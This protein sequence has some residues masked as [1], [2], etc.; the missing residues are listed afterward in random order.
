[1]NP[2]EANQ[3]EATYNAR[4]AKIRKA[5]AIALKELA[6]LRSGGPMAGEA[7][8]A[9]VVRLRRALAAKPISSR[10]RIVRIGKWLP[11]AAVQPSAASV[12][13]ACLRFSFLALIVRAMERFEAPPANSSEASLLLNSVRSVARMYRLFA[14]KWGP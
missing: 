11:P 7:F 10:H 6:R 13:A 8:D 4:V 9:E 3:F 2:G 12:F 5:A 1:M 14:I